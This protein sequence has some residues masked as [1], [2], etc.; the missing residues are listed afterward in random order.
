[1]SIRPTE[2]KDSMYESVDS[3]MTESEIKKKQVKGNYKFFLQR[4]ASK[5]T[6]SFD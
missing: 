1:M 6:E 3:D 4:A 5:V 2:L